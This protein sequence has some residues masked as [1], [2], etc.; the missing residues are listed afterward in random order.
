MKIALNWKFRMYYS[1]LSCV[2]FST[3]VLIKLHRT[4][5][6]SKITSVSRGEHEV[7][8]MAFLDSQR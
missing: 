6:Q 4:K 3:P 2:S 8:T 7:D 1:G 5:N